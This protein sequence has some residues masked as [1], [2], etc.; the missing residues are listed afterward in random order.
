MDAAAQGTSGSSIAGV[1]TDTSGA[2]LPGVTVE[3]ASP[4]LIERSRSTVTD[5][6]GEYRI[7]E[8]RPGTYTV[9]FSLGGFSS[10]KREGLELG[11]NFT[12]TV[13]V[14]MRLGAIE[15]SVTV[16]GSSPLVDTQNISR[17]T[18]I[19]KTQLDALP[20]GKNLLSFYA[21]TPALV[22]P[23]NA[24]DVGG[25]KGETSSRASL[26]GSKQGDTKMMIDGMSFNWFE[27]EGSGR[28]FYVN[29]LTAQEVVVDTPSGS[30]SAEYTSNGVVINLIPKDGGNRFSGT[31]FATG[32]D[33]SLQADN[34]T[35][36]LRAQGAQT[37]SGTRSLYD[38]NAVVAG[39]IVE[40][41]V[42]FMSAHRRWGRREQI[43]NLFHAAALNVPTFT[44]DYNNPGYP[45]E[46]FHS[47]NARVTWQVNQKNKVNVLY[48]WQLSNQSN[49]FAY[50]N[51]GV[52]SMEAGNPYCNRGQLVMGTWTSTATN[53]LLFE[54][55]L[56]YLNQWA[57]TFEHACAGIP[58]NRLYRDPTVSFP[59]NGNGPVQSDSGQTPFKQRFSM[60]YI[61]GA[62]HFKAGM[63]ADESLPRDTY[64][65]RG[66][67]PYT[68]TFRGGAPIS[69]TEY[70]SP[71]LTGEVKVRPDLAVFAQ[72]QWTVKRVT[73]NLGLRYEHHRTYASPV[74]TLPGPLVDAHTLPGL[75][76]IPCWNDLDP[77]MGVVW[78]VFGD[79]KTAV[80]ANLGRYVSL[81]SWVNSKMFNPQNAIVASTT[82]SWTTTR[83]WSPDLTPNC[84]LRN[85]FANGE[86]GPMANQS[87]GQEVINTTPDPNWISGWG[88]R[89]YSWAGS[90]SVD[91]QL[92]NGVA[93][94]V[95]YYRTT[96]G[97]FTATRNTNV[98]PSDY[99]PYCI[100]APVDPRLPSSVSGQQ[101]C[102]LYDI[103]PSK[104]GLVNNVVTLA[105]NYGNQTEY[106]NGADV[107]LVAR[108][109]HGINLSG[110]WNI[111]DAISTLQVW[112]GNV[113]SKANQ[114]FVVNSPQDQ[115]F[116]LNNG[117]LTSCAA[118]PPYQ[119]L[120]K[121]NGSVQ[122]PWA[123]Q[124][125]AVFQSIPGPNHDAL[126]TATN[127]QIAPSLGRN[128]AGGVQTVTINLVPSLSQFADYRINQLDVRLT[129]ILRL[130]RGRIQLNLDVYNALN[131]SY[132]L[133]GNTT[134]GTNGANWL[135]PTSTMDARLMKFGFQ[136][137]F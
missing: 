89:G 24:Q 11:P 29:A 104:F 80:K 127:A 103:K 27:G 42:W 122:L 92:A 86:C 74:V 98:S 19:P 39:P 52:S 6:Q 130:T 90:V 54:G 129:K 14:Q 84:D 15:E 40:D 96:F 21:L 49:N 115:Y 4:A 28:A 13:S 117:A 83:P 48:E 118:N 73:L 55:G 123:L 51:S 75:D 113:T 128:L 32:T 43:A 47:D 77:R 132:V 17:Q 37:T 46:D 20:T 95:G 120:F 126:Y 25:S 87:F 38:L 107:N 88:K 106:Y 5:A 72:D 78:D 58:T 31:F 112:P 67:T 116:Y 101:I 82:R 3:A 81:V 91:R 119:S 131:G 94:T 70:A 45:A 44:P 33:H 35:D 63:T 7:A 137:D 12:A 100:T 85:P 64:T 108:L 65:D 30:T 18:V 105:S 102:G 68:Y 53:R 1:V 125:A 2:V 34:L 76:C 79:G 16:T 97:N 71:S 109:P 8:L 114:C 136:Y 23:S 62:H 10:L 22:S 26:H 121:V 36:A 50:L 9:T 59:F 124:A 41:K 111:G 133:W 99:D 57:N 93:L 110:G 61:T 135:K 60:S 134:Y 56:L 69:L 66:P